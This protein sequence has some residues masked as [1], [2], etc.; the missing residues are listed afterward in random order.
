MT[1]F[2]PFSILFF[3]RARSDLMWVGVLIVALLLLRL[4]IEKFSLLAGFA[5]FSNRI[6]EVL[7]T[8]LPLLGFVY[9]LKWFAGFQDGDIA[10]GK[11][12]CVPDFLLYSP[13]KTIKLTIFPAVAG[14][15]FV[16]LSRFI[17]APDII[18]NE[19]LIAILSSVAVYF[20]VQAILWQ[21][22][23]VR[24][25]RG[26]LIIAV[27]AVAYFVNIYYRNLATV[28]V[29]MSLVA[30]LSVIVI[31][32]FLASYAALRNARR[33][34]AITF[35]R[36]PLSG[37]RSRVS[38][39]L[40]EEKNYTS[41]LAAQVKY[42]RGLSGYFL[43]TV[44]SLVLL[45]P[46]LILF[47]DRGEAEVRQVLFGLY[48]AS[49]FIIPIAVL[50]F[51]G[52]GRGVLVTNRDFQ[53]DNFSDFLAILPMSSASLLNA[54]YR[55]MSISGFLIYGLYF[56]FCSLSFQKYSIYFVGLILESR[57]AIVGYS[58]IATVVF[59]SL[60]FGTLAYM[61][62]PWLGSI[63]RKY[64]HA[65]KTKVL[66]IGVG[67]INIV[68]MRFLA[69]PYIKNFTADDIPDVKAAVFLLLFLKLLAFIW[70]VKQFQKLSMPLTT[71]APFLVAWVAV[72]LGL[73]FLAA[74]LFLGA[75]QD[76]YFIVSLAILLT[77]ILGIVFTYVVFAK[78][79]Y[80]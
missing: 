27:I 5:E 35:P 32:G 39:Q 71:L 23:S 51:I 20:W 1:S 28:S 34:V 57:S 70:T 11:Q 75:W 52:L 78:S 45:L 74:Q 63:L 4:P 67:L 24:Y 15:V 30:L 46:L 55:E 60:V 62:L 40:D 44:F 16:A 58:L 33:G 29:D 25:I 76:I 12:S 21:S 50:Y 3:S 56:V 69:V 72:V 9:G 73:V 19:G 42:E 66:I 13:L 53:C 79:R 22:F 65:A 80:R 59:G 6:E 38:E 7:Y 54:K 68:A 48:M 47:L 26:P 41:A 61:S 36:F 49:L 10:V 2:K 14:L 43:P 17:S 64:Q 8:T 18:F 31:L 37:K 77:P